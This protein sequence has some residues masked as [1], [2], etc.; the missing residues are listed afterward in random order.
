[1]NTEYLVI[2]TAKTDETTEA[3]VR[4]AAAK[5]YPSYIVEAVRADG[6]EWQVR[7]AK[8]VS[9]R[10]A[11]F[12]FEKKDD[13]EKPDSDSS[14]EPDEEESP[15]D[16]DTPDEKAVDDEEGKGKGEKKKS[17]PVAEFVE[18]TNKMKSLLDDVLEQAGVVKEKADKVDEMHDLIKD[19]VQGPPAEAPLP[20]EV[21]PTPG[22]PPAAAG[23]GA[24][25]M[26]PRGPRPRRLPAQRAPMP[27][28]FSNTERISSSKFDA[29]G[30]ERTLAQALKDLE[31]DPEFRGY[32]VVDLA[33][34]GDHFSALVER[35]S[36]GS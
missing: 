32:K 2:T 7:L 10:A 11:Q 18:L 31:E 21:G 16:D 5:A 29:N 17:D 19:H 6:S 15:D 3:S 33:D 35:P 22:A 4:A 14:D 28:G 9:P 12:P 36:N 13:A 23:P 27:Q 20:E 25:P 34:K 1:M 26:P 8:P 24:G 30:K